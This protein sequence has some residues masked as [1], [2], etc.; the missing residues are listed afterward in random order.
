M[1]Y[2]EVTT[3]KALSRQHTAGRP[4]LSARERLE[5]LCDPGLVQTLWTSVQSP[6]LGLKA[7]AGDGVL[8]ASG[9]VERPPIFC[10]AQDGGLIGRSLGEAHAESI[11]CCL[12][13]ARNA[14]VP[15]VGL[16]R[17]GWRSDKRG[18]RRA[19]RVRACAQREREAVRV[20]AS[21]LDR[22]GYVRGQRLV[23]RRGERP[24]EPRRGDVEGYSRRPDGS[25]S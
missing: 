25:K 1:R 15:A 21:D 7:R 8:V 19:Q 17:I 16:G 12:W 6:Q 23:L 9:T 2:V 18:C 3:T 11:I 13:L 14:K 20:R 22:N 10:Y 4:A 5:A 24:T